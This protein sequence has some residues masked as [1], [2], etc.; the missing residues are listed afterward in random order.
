MSG[1]AAQG[2]G[3]GGGAGDPREP[4]G[5]PSGP[6]DSDGRDSDGRDSDGRDAVPSALGD[7]LM[8]FVREH[9]LWPVTAVAALTAAAFGASVISLALDEGSLPARGALAILVALSIF[10]MEPEIRRRR[11]GIATGI[12]VVLWA[13][14]IGG[15]LLSAF[16]LPSD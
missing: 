11:P 7:H 1:P 10:A 9:T 5:G 6:R 8:I 15:S 14:S 12:V 13:L 3:P 16:W 2:G 4:A